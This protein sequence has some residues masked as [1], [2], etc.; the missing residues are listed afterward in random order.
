M[1]MGVRGSG[2]TATAVKLLGNSA[3]DGRIIAGNATFSRKKFAE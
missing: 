2:I 3:I 1:T